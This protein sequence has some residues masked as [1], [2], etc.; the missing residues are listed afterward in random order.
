M[1]YLSILDLNGNPL[2]S[3]VPLESSKQL[4]WLNI[5]GSLVSNLTPLKGLTKL[6]SLQIS[7]I[8]GLETIEP[9]ASLSNLKELQMKNVLVDLSPI[10]SLKNLTTLYLTDGYDGDLSALKEIYPNLKDKNFD[11][12]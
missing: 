7:Y 2:W 3:V 11:M 12:K 6:E 4:T 8:P 10:A 9:I 1:P 5:S